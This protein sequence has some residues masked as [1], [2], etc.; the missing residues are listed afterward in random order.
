MGE[1]TT[2]LRLHTLEESNKDL[3]KKLGE[4]NGVVIDIKII[5][6]S[7]ALT[8][9]IIMNCLKLIAGAFIVFVVTNFMMYYV[10]KYNSV[11]KQ[12]ATNTQIK[13]TSTEVK[14]LSKNKYIW[15]F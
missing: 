4:V 1:E 9:K 6:V 14:S 8:L 11:P 15:R 2:D 10:S 7:Q 5:N 12:P 3:I 13:A